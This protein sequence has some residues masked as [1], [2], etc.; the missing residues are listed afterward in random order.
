[1]EI[2]AEQKC[3][4]K[5]TDI[6]VDCLEYIFNCL[7]LI[8]LLNVADSS[9]YLG[10]VGEP[11][12]RRKFG[13]NTI[14]LASVR[15]SWKRFYEVHSDCKL[16]MDFKTSLQLLR[17][18]GHLVARIEF[19]SNVSQKCVAHISPTESAIR[20]LSYI[21]EYCAMHLSEIKLS[22][23]KQNALK[24]L[25]KPF[26]KVQKVDISC[27]SFDENWLSR[28]FP[29][30][31]HLTVTAYRRYEPFDFASIA[32]HFPRMKHLVLNCD[33]DTTN[34]LRHMDNLV[35]AI[36]LNPQLKTFKLIYF[37]KPVFD[38]SILQQTY[39]SFQNLE[40]FDVSYDF[41]EFRNFN[42][43]PLHFK[44]VKKL[45]LCL[46]NSESGQAMPNIPLS[47][48]Q[49][50]EFT[51]QTNFSLRNAAF[52]DF[53]D[54]HPNIKKLTLEWLL[55]KSDMD[56][57]KLAAALPCLAEIH[58]RNCY[59]TEN[60]AIDFM[61]H[62]KL[63]KKFSFHYC[64]NRINEFKKAMGNEWTIEIDQRDRIDLERII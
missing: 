13:K 34:R 1:M 12:F 10:R 52:F 3:T 9:K 11:I 57:P 4:T 31:Q 50:E 49:L 60:D 51:F 58:I 33:Y 2:D 27:C 47:F 21:N 7:D 62:F 39:A 40:T 30:M 37:G 22:D 19:F 38:M 17:C 61:A 24:C 36:R 63:L 59:F 54:K 16:I 53:I 41:K 28:F 25:T 6:D 23:C 55:N 35:A 56:A 64:G 8:D 14:L 26:M 15:L 32:C 42:G 48:G 20:I 43:H 45:S 5:M 18:F 46:H 44:N 29:N